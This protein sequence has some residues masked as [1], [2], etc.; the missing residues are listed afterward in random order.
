MSRYAFEEADIDFL[1]RLFSDFEDESK[2]LAGK[3]LLYPAYEACLKCSHVFNLLDA[4][5]AISVTERTSFIA[6]VRALSRACARLYLQWREEEG[7][8]L[9]GAWAEK[10]YGH[11]SST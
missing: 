6:R 10:E 2:G 9:T 7:Y 3:G 1:Y 4:R 8:P 5:G 11:G